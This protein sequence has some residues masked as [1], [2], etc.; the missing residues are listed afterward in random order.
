MFLRSNGT[1]GSTVN[2]YTGG[3]YEVYFT[4]DSGCTSS[5]EISVP[6]SPQE[7]MWNFPTGCFC[8]DD[9]RRDGCTGGA[10][11]VGPHT[12]FVHWGYKVNGVFEL[13]GS[14]TYPTAFT[15]IEPDSI[16]LFLDN[17]Y[18]EILSDPMYYSDSCA[19]EA[20]GIV[21]AGNS[22]GDLE[23]SENEEF[24]KRITNLQPEIRLIPNPA[25]GQTRIQYRFDDSE[26]QRTIEVYDMTGRKVNTLRPQTNA[27]SI[28]L[29]LGDF[30]SGIYQVCLRQDG[31][32]LAQSKL[33][34]TP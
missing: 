3:L 23:M 2:G 25:A 18:C 11:I 9:L 6:S 14:G 29:Q 30:R 22:A 12:P 26:N 1:A 33:S 19:T 7:Y 4:S 13:T 21:G 10:A 28:I 15:D 27:G 16:Q 17:G 20:Q 32:I 5:N 8:E 31:R 34:V 24:S